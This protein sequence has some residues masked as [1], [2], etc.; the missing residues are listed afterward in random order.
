MREKKIQSAVV[1]GDSL[2]RGVIFD[3]KRGRYSIAPCPAADLV[4]QELGI[5][6]TNRSRMGLTT[7]QGMQMMEKDLEK[8]LHADAAVLEFGGNDCDFDWKAISEAPDQDHQPKTPAIQF[9][10]NMRSMIEKVQQAGMEPVLVNLPPINAERYFHFLS[11]GGLSQ[12]NILRWLG[13]TFQI[14]RYQERYSMIVTRIAQECGCRLLDIRSAFLNIWNSAPFLCHDGIHP[15]A[16]GQ[17][18]IGKTI[19]AEM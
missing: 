4:A 11:K 10:K 18:L 7:T 17:E 5:D 6:I 19:L 2:A 12:G 8:G 1:W 15:T 13:E 16:Q 14:Y 3:E 9:E